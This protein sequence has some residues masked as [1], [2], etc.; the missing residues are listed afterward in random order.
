M[1]KKCLKVKRFLASALILL[2]LVFA[3]GIP[4]AAESAA[5]NGFSE[6]DVIYFIMTDRFENGDKSNDY[7]SNPKDLRAYHGG[8]FQGIINKLDYIKDLGVTAIW[9]TPVVSNDPGGYHGY[10]A[11]D[12]YKVDKHLGD[13][14]KLK[15]LVRTAREKGIKV[16]IDQVVNHTG[17][18]HPFVSDEKYEDWFHQ[19][20]NITNWDDQNEVETG[21]LAGLPDFA[22]ENPAVSKYL[23]DMSKWWIKETGIDGFRLDTVKHVPKSF[24]MEFSKEIKKDYPDF[25]LMG[26][27]WS[28]D[29]NYLN[30]YQNVGLD[31]LVDFPLYF[32]ISDVFARS[33]K[34]SIL[35]N[36]IEAGRVYTN[37][38]M[39][40][41]FIDNHDVAR[42]ASLA[43][44]LKE[45]KLK[46]ALVFQ[47]T[48]TGIPI[49]YYGTEIA[50]EGSEDPSN[51]KSMDWSKESP[52]RD[53]MKQLI[54]IRKSNPCFSKGDIKVLSAA[55]Y[56]IAYERSY[57]ES[58][59]IVMLNNL[60]KDDVQ[61]VKL[62]QDYIPKGFQ[63]VNALDSKDVIRQVKNNEV[64]VQ[65]K[66]KESK[67][68]ILQK[69]GISLP[70]GW[71][72]VGLVA[73]IG[74]LAWMMRRNKKTK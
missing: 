58:K 74:L 10:W 24:W 13:M 54:S 16:M 22:Q 72:A 42:F 38:G 62:A 28:G 47:L 39:Y 15:E 73:L 32:S 65:M 4:A 56:F 17:V 27:V 3:A 67:V 20:G 30:S 34:M 25:Y 23:I 19:T 14:D 51:R 1:F 9:I 2:L 64:S 57:E 63:L 36:A 40:G 6:E 55:D 59:A 44:T 61:V 21:K 8:D 50:M 52:V 66:P 70:Y 29:A 48:Y 35:S 26:E 53:Y 11:N 49:I 5:R 18:L 69:Q 31:G 60:N 7:R 46:Q 12:F 41:T 68:Y 37:R 33:K 45:E 71:S 43:G